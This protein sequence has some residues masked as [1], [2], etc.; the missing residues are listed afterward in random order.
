MRILFVILTLILTQSTSNAQV[1]S[2]TLQ[3]D[4]GSRE[5]L[6][7]LPPGYQFAN[8]SPVIFAMHGLNNPPVDFMPRTLFNDVA[9]TANFITVYPAALSS[10]IGTSW[11]SGTDPTQSA[12]DVGFID[13]L[14][15]TMKFLA[16]I[17]LNRV[18]VCGFSQGGFMT[19]RLACQLTNRITA[20]ATIAG[21]MHTTVEASCVLSKPMPALHAHGTADNNVSINGNT[22]LGL[23]SAN[24]LVDF[25]INENN[26][27]IPPIT[28]MLPDTYADGLT[29]DLTYYPFCDQ[30]TEVVFYKVNGLDHNW[31]GP[32]N[33][34]Y[35]AESV[36]HFFRKYGV[37][38]STPVEAVKQ[39][40]IS[41]YPTLATNEIHIE[42]A[43]GKALWIH[44]INGQVMIEKQVENN[45]Y[46]TINIESF[47]SGSYIVTI[48]N[49]SFKIIRF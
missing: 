18:Y 26:C 10:V 6:Y 35:Y 23:L 21:T 38:T 43:N 33:D 39:Q 19:S 14:I 36:W 44:S 34:I 47:P 30:Q 2:A 7:Y 49:Q 41:V 42:G 32:S 9:D 12:D 24:D 5:F 28:S 45:D 40:E 46:Y 11:N 8:E 3:H 15:D 22:F 27:A 1:V 37:P 20:I 16:N 4:G 17:D 31:T 13:A 48:D 29:V 25:W